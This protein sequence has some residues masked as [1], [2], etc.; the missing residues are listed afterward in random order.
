M[1][2]IQHPTCPSPS[3]LAGN[4]KFPENKEAL[5]SASHSKC[6][7]C[8]SKVDHVYPGD[9]EHLKPKSIFPELEFSW[10]NLGYVCS[11]CNN[12][13]NDF[14]STTTPLIDPY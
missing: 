9:V 7:Y 12:S 10:P 13:K 6:A 3:K 4:Y 2:K 14:Y 5:I 1:R 8:E 11:V